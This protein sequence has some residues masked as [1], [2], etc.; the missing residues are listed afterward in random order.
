[1]SEHSV[2]CTDA[3]VDCEDVGKYDTSVYKAK[4][5][6]YDSSE[7]HDDLMWLC[8]RDRAAESWLYMQRST[9]RLE[10]HR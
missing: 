3:F 2:G 4:H 9:L 5:G 10:T 8:A 6:R 1:M 7:P